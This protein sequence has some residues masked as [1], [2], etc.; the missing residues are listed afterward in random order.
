MK[1]YKER[2]GKLDMNMAKLYSKL[3]GQ[4]TE[5][6]VAEIQADK[7]YEVKSAARDPVWLLTCIKKVMAGINSSRNKV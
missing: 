7:A 3:I 2:R 4:C 1:N 5:T 6:M